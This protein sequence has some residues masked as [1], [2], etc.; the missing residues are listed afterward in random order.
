[1]LESRNLLF[2]VG[3]DSLKS[4]DVFLHWPIKQNGNKHYTILLLDITQRTYGQI[5]TY[6]DKV[7]WQ[8][9]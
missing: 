1:M 2:K 3:L 8:T 6:I 5:V 9:P 7:N 4:F